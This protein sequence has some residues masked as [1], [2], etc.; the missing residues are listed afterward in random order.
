MVLGAVPFIGA[1]LLIYHALGITTIWAGFLFLLYWMGLMQSAMKAWLPALLGA[2]GGIALGWILIAL[3]K[4]VGMP[5]MVGGGVL[6]A[7]IIFFFIR[8]QFAIVINNAMMILLTVATIPQ[9]NVGAN[10][11]EMAVAVVVAALYTWVFATATAW[12]M[13]RRAAPADGTVQ[14]AL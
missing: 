1:L 13:S 14:P 6:L 10:A 2:L 5:A 12:V 9:V 8:G 4:I 7:A 3:P 11:P